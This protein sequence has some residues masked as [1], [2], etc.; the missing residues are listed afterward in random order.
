MTFRFIVLLFALCLTGCLATRINGGRIKHNGTILQ[1]GQDA[2]QSST[3]EQDNERVETLRVPAG[4]IMMQGTNSFKVASD[5]TFV[6]SSHDKLKSSLGAAQK[7]T[8][9]ETA[10]K[11]AS[12]SWLTYLGAVLVLFGGASA[13]YPPLKLIVNSL[14]TSVVCVVTGIAFIALPVVIVG[15]EILILSIGLGAVVIYF[16]AHRHGGLKGE[17]TALKGVLNKDLTPK[18]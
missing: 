1:Q 13:V 11:L 12:L 16:F 17:L 9:A 18:S 15:H 3:L 2:K 6:I 8:L 14:T 7:N 10:A 4:S 5:T